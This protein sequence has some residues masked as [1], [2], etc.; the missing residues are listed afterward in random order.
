MK[1][2]TNNK[3]AVGFGM[4]LI[5]LVINAVVT[6]RNTLKAI[7]DSYLVSNSNEVLAALEG[8]ISTLKDAETGQRG[9]LITCWIIVSC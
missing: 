2:A 6:Y 5:I 1:W 3:I 8:T 7:N 9:Y 4:T